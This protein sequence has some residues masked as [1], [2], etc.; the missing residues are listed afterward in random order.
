MWR[1]SEQLH[2]LDA[3][4]PRRM[5]SGGLRGA[6]FSSI[7]PCGAAA[8]TRTDQT[9]DFNWPG[10]SPDASVPHDGFSARWTGKLTP[11][12]GGDYR[13][14]TRA[15]DGVRLWVDGTLVLDRWSDRALAADADGDGAV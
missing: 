14:I 12:T 3:L 2:R 7:D 15:D 11:T 13:L 8:T 1:R 9:V 4:E 6:Y 10:T 5:V